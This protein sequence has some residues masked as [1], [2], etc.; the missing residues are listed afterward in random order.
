MIDNLKQ[1]LLDFGA[2]YQIVL[3][4]KHGSTPQTAGSTIYI[5]SRDEIIGTIGG[6][7]IEYQSL[8]LAK[9][10]KQNHLSATATFL[11]NNQVAAA[12]GMICG[13]SNS[14]LFLP[15]DPNK[16][17]IDITSANENTDE[18]PEDADIKSFLEEN[19]LI[20]M[21]EKELNSNLSD[22]IKDDFQSVCSNLKIFSTPESL[23]ISEFNETKN[24]LTSSKIKSV[25]NLK[26]K[27]INFRDLRKSQTIDVE[28]KIFFVQHLVKTPQVTILGGGHVAQ[29]LSKLLSF[30]GWEHAILEDRSEFLRPELFGDNADRVLVDYK[31]LASSYQLQDSHYYCVMTRGHKSDFVVVEQI[32]SAI[33]PKYLG[34]MGSR[35]KVVKLKEFLEKQNISEQKIK[36]IFAPIGEDISSVTVEEI[37]V[38][39]AAELIRVYRDH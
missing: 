2:E 3:T 22:H 9:V 27:E 23:F 33:D 31:N 24:L 25:D 6:G 29:A 17:F 19:L 5:N 20:R 4:A 13:G 35:R 18:Q 7:L 28:G 38:S 1:T 12:A 10:L 16:D 14:V 26:A 39:I 36:G 30:L 8:N 32:L 21:P 15:I 11:M 37:A 34:V